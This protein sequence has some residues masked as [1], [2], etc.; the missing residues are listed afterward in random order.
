MA[1]RVSL[2]RA[3]IGWAALCLLSGCGEPPPSPVPQAP[4]DALREKLRQTVSL[5]EREAPLADVLA[6]LAAHCDVE[7]RLDELPVVS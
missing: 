7:I 3:L 2:A 6:R 1:N 4:R 5:D